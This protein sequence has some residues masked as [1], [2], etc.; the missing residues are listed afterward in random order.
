MMN[1]PMKNSRTEV[2]NHLAT[3]LILFPHLFRLFACLDGLVFEK[4]VMNLVPLDP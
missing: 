2:F 3:V 4:P 1:G